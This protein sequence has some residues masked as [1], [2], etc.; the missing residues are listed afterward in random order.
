MNS[1]LLATIPWW[2]SVLA[3]I[4]IVVCLALVVLVLLQKGRGGGLAAAFG[5]AGGQSAFG[6]KTGDVFTWAT[7]VVVAVFLLLAMTLT[8][9]YKPV[10]P[11]EAMAAPA[12]STPPGAEP[13]PAAPAEEPTAVDTHGPV[14]ADGETTLP[15]AADETAD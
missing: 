11:D 14:E 9:N 13:L 1:T 15:A 10:N 8:M 3:V 4:F 6:S 2:A 5:G 7:I 12:S